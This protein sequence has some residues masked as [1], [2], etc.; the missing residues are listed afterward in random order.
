MK[1]TRSPQPMNFSPLSICKHFLLQRGS[2]EKF[3]FNK[4]LISILFI[5]L[6][7]FNNSSALPTHDSQNK[8]LPSL[9]PMLEKVTPA[10]VNISTKGKYQRK[11]QLPDF[12][13][14]PLFQR[15]FRFELPERNQ[16]QS[17]QVH[18]LGSG[19]IV[20]AEKGY[21]LT[22]NHVIDNASEI[23]VTLKDGRKLV[24]ELI[25]TDPQTDIAVLKINDTGLTALTLSDS[26]TLRVGDFALAIGHPFGLDQTVTS[27]IVSGLG[28]NGLGVEAYEDFI[29][30]DAS[31]NPGNS[32]GALVNLHGELIGIN[33]A[34]FSKSSGNIGIG[35]AI[36]INMAKAVM[37]Q[38]IQHGSIQRG[39]LGVQIQDL[40]PELASAIGTDV[41]QGAIVSQVIP[42]SAA[43]LAG[44]K[45]GDIIVAV[46]EKEINNS[47]SLRN[48]IGLKQPGDSVKLSIIRGD[49]SLSLT[50]II[51]TPQSNL[52][53]DSNS[54]QSPVF[55]GQ[56]LHSS[57]TGADL[58]QSQD[59]QGIQVINVESQSPAWRSGLRP[60]DLIIAINRQEVNSL[61]DL[62]RIAKNFKTNRQ[63]TIALNIHRGRTALF[64]VIR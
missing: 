34:M 64:L 16:Q 30:T 47:R 25:G 43:S 24:A 15:F 42:N 52:S 9:A 58:G 23:L 63:Q 33:T 36:P 48:T 10:V 8:E 21:I 27:G 38:L 5:S 49:K 45:A 44:V 14:D 62:K 3:M 19:V 54:S 11:S 53:T 1:N 2:G 41:T 61:R 13:N 59:R 37:T 17:Q 4:S 57:L 18:A 51:S 26:D 32:G 50:A 35:F 56:Q 31:I 20:N 28:R 60:D 12:L 55:K 40:T 29:Q 22:N 6:L 7:L 46:N 39:M